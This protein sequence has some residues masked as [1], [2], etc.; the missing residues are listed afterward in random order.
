MD[1]IGGG[2]IA[3]PSSFS[4]LPLVVWD[5]EEGGDFLFLFDGVDLA[6]KKQR[7]VG[8]EGER[9]RQVKAGPYYPPTNMLSNAIVVEDTTLACQQ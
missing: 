2:V 1:P 3:E 5:G 7:N 8:G 6:I 9:K 4:L